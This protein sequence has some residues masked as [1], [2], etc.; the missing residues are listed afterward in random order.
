MKNVKALFLLSLMSFSSYSGASDTIGDN[1]YT[2]S[3]KLLGR[4]VINTSLKGTWFGLATS[5]EVV[6]GIVKRT[7]AAH[8]VCFLESDGSMLCDGQHSGT[9][10]MLKNE[11]PWTGRLY[12]LTNQVHMLVNGDPNAD[13]AGCALY[14]VQFNRSGDSLNATLLAPGECNGVAGVFWEMNHFVKVSDEVDYTLA[15]DVI[16]V[17]D[18]WVKD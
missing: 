1:V 4:E 7:D 9:D 18:Q 6:G 5:L 17:T 12:Y 13:S 2:P 8:L 10:G 16:K 14:E 15:L 11:V 3:G